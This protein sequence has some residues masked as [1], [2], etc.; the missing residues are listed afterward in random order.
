VM[1]VGGS[2]CECC[3]LHEGTPGR[4]AGESVEKGE[5]GGRKEKKRKRKS[6]KRKARV[7]WGGAGFLRRAAAMECGQKTEGLE[8][9]R[10]KSWE[11][12]GSEQDTTCARV[13]I[14][15]GLDVM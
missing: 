5:G 4:M 10:P 12:K 9:G 8:K 11:K 14:L 2:P 3:A 6:E 13:P 7:A 15:T 1:L